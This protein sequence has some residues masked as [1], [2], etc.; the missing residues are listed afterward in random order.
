[1]PMTQEERE[2]VRIRNLI[3]IFQVL[4]IKCE[5]GGDHYEAG[6]EA[7]KA[8]VQLGEPAAIGLR[9]VVDPEWVASVISFSQE[10][11]YHP[12]FYDEVDD[13]FHMLLTLPFEVMLGLTAGARTSG[14]GAELIDV[15]D[16]E[17]NAVILKT[18][19]AILAAR[20]GVLV[21]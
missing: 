13:L 8:L 4:K 19:K 3:A 15:R 9:T 11:N 20:Y 21:K 2:A 1:M 5:Q 10:R 7:G 16:D 17:A 14:L 6:A 12:E 18:V